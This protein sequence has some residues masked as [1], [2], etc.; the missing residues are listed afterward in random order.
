LK[1][2]DINPINSAVALSLSAKEPT[3]AG[4]GSGTGLTMSPFHIES[5]HGNEKKSIR[6]R[7][8]EETS[9]TSSAPAATR[10]LP[11]S[12]P[13]SLSVNQPAQDHDSFETTTAA[14]PQLSNTSASGSAE[15]DSFDVDKN[16]SASPPPMPPV[17]MLGVMRQQTLGY[18]E[19]DDTALPSPVEDEFDLPAD[20]DT[21]EGDLAATTPKNQTPPPPMP[22]VPMLGVM[23]QQTL[24]YDEF[25]DTALP[26]PVEDE[27]DLPGAVDYDAFDPTMIPATTAPAAPVTTDY[28]TFE[29]GSAVANQPSSVPSDVTTEATEE[30]TQEDYGFFRNTMTD[31]SSLSSPPSNPVLDSTP[32]LIRMKTNRDFESNQMEEIIN[33]LDRYRKYEINEL[34]ETEAEITPV[35]QA[36]EYR[37]ELMIRQAY[38]E[39]R[40]SDLYQDQDQQS[41]S[42]N[43]E[44]S[45]SMKSPSNQIKSSSNNSSSVAGGALCSPIST[46]LSPDALTAFSRYDIEAVDRNREVIRATDRLIHEIIPTLASHLALMSR[47]E[48]SHLDLSV[49]FHSH[50]VNIRHMGLVRSH[51]PGSPDNVSIRT[52]LLLNIVCRTLKNIARE[53]QRRWMKSEQ[54]SSEQGILILL[55]QFLNLIV[56]KHINSDKF[57]SERVLVGIFQRFGKCALDG[58][59]AHLQAIRKSPTFLTVSV[60]TTVDA[61]VL[62]SFVL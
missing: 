55:T 53:F 1:Q 40:V 18:D 46:P 52:Y 25:D 39:A 31:Y 43:A 7:S 2:E 22:P 41:S 37:N 28:D 10:P 5:P 48:I 60:G 57:W 42:S 62:F 58:N 34:I 50:G 12:P 17:P 49:F 54:S 45:P 44:L 38:I 24:G 19:F 14:R 15:Y 56:G 59:D 51:I 4:S 61:P 6:M 33:L 13:R 29:S 11:A 9:V 47:E 16:L 35:H 36:N 32:S 3:A 27:F 30:K 23:R 20:Y 21:F 8:G 26:S